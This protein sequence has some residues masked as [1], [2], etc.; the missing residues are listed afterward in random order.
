MQYEFLG[1]KRSMLFSKKFSFKINV[2]GSFYI[3]C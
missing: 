2:D 1:D 3:S